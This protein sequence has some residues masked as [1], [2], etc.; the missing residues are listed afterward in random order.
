[1]IASLLAA[2]AV[3]GSGLNAPPTSP[4]ELSVMSYNVHGVPWPF[5]LGRPKALSE[6][7]APLAKRRAAGDQPHLVLLQEAFTADAKAIAREAGYAYA[8]TGPARDDRAADPA[9]ADSRQFLRGAS[10]LKGE[11]DGTI[12]DSGL[13]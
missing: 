2:A 5:A 8:V 11:A 7:G 4:A 10:M 12:E 3:A 9:S 13:M 1:M 6:I